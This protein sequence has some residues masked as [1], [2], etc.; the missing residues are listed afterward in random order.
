M[1]TGDNVHTAQAIAAQVGIDQAKGDLLPTDK[2]QAIE[3]LYAQGRRVGMVGD[4]INDAPSW[5][6]RRS[7][8]RWPPPAPIPPSKPPM[9][10]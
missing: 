2:L 9:S 10:P 7:V 3:D 5:R 8:S 1:L 4:G 6:E